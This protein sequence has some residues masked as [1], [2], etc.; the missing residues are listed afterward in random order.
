MPTYDYKCKECKVITT[1]TH[2]LHGDHTQVCNVCG[3]PM[4]K[5]FGAVPAS[6]KGEGFYTTDKFTDR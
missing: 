2:S 5:Q 6:F 3:K 1:V 4:I